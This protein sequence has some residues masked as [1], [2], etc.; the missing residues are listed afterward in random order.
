MVTLEITTKIQNMVMGDKR[1][2]ERYIASA[3]E[4]SQERVHPILTKD[5]GMRKLPAHRVPRLQKQRRQNMSFANLNL[6][7]L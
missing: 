7:E 3:V 6:F 2:R 4:I 1:V 5:L